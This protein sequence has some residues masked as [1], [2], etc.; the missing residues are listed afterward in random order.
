MALPQGKKLAALGTGN[1]APPSDGQAAHLPGYCHLVQHCTGFRVK[2]KQSILTADE[3]CVAGKSF[4]VDAR[5]RHAPETF[6]RFV[7]GD[8]K[9]PGIRE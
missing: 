9:G 6:H 1:H 2:G 8:F 3:Q 7:S 5:A 4:A